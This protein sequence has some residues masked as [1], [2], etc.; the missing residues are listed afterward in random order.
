MAL[1]RADAANLV[2]LNPD[3]IVMTGDRVIPIL[4]RLTRSIPIVVAAT[5]DPIASGVVESLGAA[6]WQRD[7]I[8]ADRVLDLI[9][10]HLLTSPY[11]T[12]E[13]SQPRLGWSAFWGATDHRGRRP[14]PH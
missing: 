11:G 3:V 13:P 5:S 1:V 2:A 6:G 8:F 10:L 4:T 9:L 12:Q 7:W 14:G